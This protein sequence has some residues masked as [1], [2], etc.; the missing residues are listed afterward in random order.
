[1]LG[2]GVTL[3]VLLLFVLSACCCLLA[4]LGLYLALGRT[5]GRSAQP[6]RGGRR[7]G[8]VEAE[9]EGM[10]ASGELAEEGEG[11]VEEEEGEEEL[12]VSGPWVA[13]EERHG[14]RG[15]YVL[16]DLNMD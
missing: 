14:G 2:S 11:E 9:E 5:A 16:G 10:L 12:L 1:M 6:R 4:A 7:R 3:L 13:K 15:R 8:R